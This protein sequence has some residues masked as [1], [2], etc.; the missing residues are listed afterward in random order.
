MNCQ[1]V[2]NLLIRYDEGDL[3]Q[4][5]RRQVEQHLQHC[6]ECRLNLQ[7]ITQERL[8][9]K[10][11]DDIPELPSAFSKQVMSQIL[12]VPNEMFSI[13]PRFIPVF[14]T[15][16]RY[17]CF[18]GAV[19]V[20][21]FFIAPYF[22][23]PMHEKYVREPVKTAT[24]NSSPSGGLSR[25]PAVNPPVYRHGQSETPSSPSRSLAAVLQ[26]S[27]NHK[28]QSLD[29]TNE[30][31][32]SEQT[33]N[34]MM[35]S[36]QIKSCHEVLP[37][38]VPAGYT[39]NSVKRDNSD[40]WILS[41]TLQNKESDQPEQLTVFISP[42]TLQEKVGGTFSRAEIARSLIGPI[43]NENQDYSSSAVV[44][45]DTFMVEVEGSVYEVTVNPLLPEEELKNFLA[46]F[47][48]SL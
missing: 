35:L 33:G 26:P 47:K 4:P 18:I 19:A 34:K 39:L 28:T 37:S 36:P 41:Y 43:P 40:R 15:R 21:L 29:V 48:S 24:V 3:P 45:E 6:A 5:L 42:I 14:S 12:P 44:G 13:K 31:K 46:S 30:A 1:Q 11:V 2:N 10:S 32:S 8:C 17:I 16:L 22:S 27:E 38:Y 9:L 7:L 20:L 25:L 23:L